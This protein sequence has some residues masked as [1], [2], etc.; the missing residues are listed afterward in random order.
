MSPRSN[1]PVVKEVSRDPAINEMVQH[2]RAEEIAT[3]W[4][5]YQ[6]QQPQC[7]FGADGVC[8]RLCHMG[9]CRITPRPPYGI[10]GA[11]ADT[12]AARNLLREI[13]AGT[14]AH[15]DHGRMLVRTLKRVAEGKGGEYKINDPRRLRE[16]ARFFEIA[17]DGR[18]DLEIAGALADFFMGAVRLVGGAQPDRCAWRRRSA[19]RSGRSWRSSRP[20]VDRRGRGAACT[21]PT[22][23]WTTTTAT[24]SWAG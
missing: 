6:S 11:D 14:A 7:K 10:C 15:S 21:A 16:A 12:I 24:C 18:T 4:D 3:V 9:P 17:V 22:W 5:R 19:R 2:A 13:A 1:S 23:A 8:C 20:G